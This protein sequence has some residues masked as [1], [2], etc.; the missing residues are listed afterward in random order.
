MTSP[1]PRNKCSNTLLAVLAALVLGTATIALVLRL[2]QL[3]V[4][5]PGIASAS[6]LAIYCLLAGGLLG[7]CM[8]AM[9]R[10]LIAINW[11]GEGFSYR[12]GIFRPNTGRWAWDAVQAELFRGPGPSRRPPPFLLVLRHGSEELRVDCLQ[13][14]WRAV[15]PFLEAL[16]Q[17][18]PV[19]ERPYDGH[20]GDQGPSL[21]KTMRTFATSQ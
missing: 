17:R 11:D 1:N 14:S 8:F 6:A 19:T 16:R 20:P 15:H 7:A 5:K 2:I 9:R 10:R 4:Q 21:R 18:I 13:M 12:V 3:A